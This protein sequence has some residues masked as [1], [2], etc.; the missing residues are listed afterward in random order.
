[1]SFLNILSIEGVASRRPGSISADDPE[2]VI[3]RVLAD[4]DERSAGNPRRA[5]ADLR[6]RLVADPSFTT[7]RAAFIRW[8]VRMD[9]AAWLRLQGWRPANHDPRIWRRSE[10]A[11]DEAR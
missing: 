3:H 4:V 6:D 5:I 10:F 9:D 2:Q 7:E 8:L 1:M 11:A